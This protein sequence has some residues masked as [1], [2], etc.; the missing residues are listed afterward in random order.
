[1]NNK[2]IAVVLGSLLAGCSMIPRDFNRA[3]KMT[4]V[5]SGLTTKSI[6][7]GKSASVDGPS[8]RN[9][10]WTSSGKD[11]FRDS[12]AR[13]V[14]DVI[15]VKIAMNDKATLDSSSRRSRDAKSTG[16]G[17]LNY[18]VGI[19]GFVRSGSGSLNSDIASNTSTTGQGKVERSETIE[20]LVAAVV[21]KV[22]PNGNLLISGNQEVRVNHEMRILKVAGIVQPRDISTGNTISYEKIAEARISYGGRGRISEIQQP[23]WGQQLLDALNPF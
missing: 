14:G 12:R 1:M 18:D 9:S 15:T 8:P 19:K 5:G 21:S 22:L 2:V 7:L 6:G 3:P 16:S 13:T 10:T 20:F 17:S 23:G 11:L 4:P